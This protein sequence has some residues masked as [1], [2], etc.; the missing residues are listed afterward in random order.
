MFKSNITLIIHS[1][2]ILH[3]ENL[4]KII[5][6]LFNYLILCYIICI[7]SFLQIVV[8]NIILHIVNSYK[9]CKFI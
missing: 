9:H 2:Q 5:K 1:N 3:Y 6:I 4:N 8:L 7:E